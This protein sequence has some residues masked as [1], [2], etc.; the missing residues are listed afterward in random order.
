VCACVCV[1]CVYVCVWCVCV[2]VCEWVL[3]M[4]VCACV[5]VVCVCVLCMCVCVCVCVYWRGKF[6][7]KFLF[8]LQHK[9][10]V[11]H[12]RFSMPT[13]LANYM[14][15]RRNEPSYQGGKPNFKKCSLTSCIRP[16]NCYQSN[17]QA[18]KSNFWPKH[19]I[20]LI[21]LPCLPH[22]TSIAFV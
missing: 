11:E 5:R 14:L 18:V 20:N 4:C 16:I 22:I 12:P 2:C 9:G 19:D 3:C 10:G 7:N 8:V 21:S 13:S 6:R 1:V 15:H 17:L